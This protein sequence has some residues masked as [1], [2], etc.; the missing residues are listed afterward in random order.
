MSTTG[1]AELSAQPPSDL[2]RALSL[3]AAI[4]AGMYVVARPIASQF[5]PYSPDVAFTAMIALMLAA[6]ISLKRFLSK[7]ETPHAARFPFSVAAVL[8]LF[9]ALHVIGLIRS[10]N[11]G[12]GLPQFCDIAAYVLLLLCGFELNRHDR[13]LAML[14]I[15]G[16]LGIIAV[17]AFAGIW[18]HHIDLPRLW[19]A[20]DAG[21]EA[22]PPE[23]QS[24]TGQWRFRGDDAFATFG[25]PNSLAGFMLPGICLLAGALFSPRAAG[26]PLNFA[27]VCA[28]ALIAMM[29]WALWVTHSKGGCVAA[30]AGLWFLALQHLSISRPKLSRALAWLTAAGIFGMVVLL[31]LGLFGVLGARPFGD[32]IQ[33]RLE[34]WTSALGMIRDHPFAGTGLYGFPENYTFYKLPLG[35]EVK[36][37]H[38]DYINL[39]AEL[40]PLAPLCYLALW[41]FV[42]KT[43]VGKSNVLASETG[44]DSA[45][46]RLHFGLI[47]GG[48]LALLMLYVAFHPF[49]SAEAIAFLSG[50]PGSTFSGLLHTLALPL[51]FGAV[52]LIL[53]P[54]FR[55]GTSWIPGARAAIGAVLIHQIV[56]FDIKAQAVAAAIF[57]LGGMLL[58]QRR[59]SSSDS[60]TPPPHRSYWFA[61][62]LRANHYAARL[63][64]PLLAAALFYPAVV[65]PFASGLPRANAESMQVDARQ[66]AM[67][68]AALHIK[69]GSEAQ[70]VTLREEIADAWKNA[71]DAAPY[72]A[73]A[74]TEYAMA[75]EA[76]RQIRPESDRAAEVKNYLEKAAALRPLAPS[77]KLSLGDYI[78][79]SAIRKAAG[80]ATQKAAAAEALGWY[81]AAAARY[82]FAPGMRLARGDALLLFGDADAADGAYLEALR[83]DVAILDVNVYLSSIFT[84]SRPG[85][86]VKHGYDREILSR[87]RSAKT[88]SRGLLLRRVIS[89]AWLILQGR[90][91]PGAKPDDLKGLENEMSTTIEDLISKTEDITERAHLAL[92]AALS[93][94]LRR[95]DTQPEKKTQDWARARTLQKLSAQQ[96]K[97][98]SPAVM[99]DWLS[100]QY[101]PV[102]AVP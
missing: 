11:L 65:V 101:G 34:Y 47:G 100:K 86:F 73:N 48:V 43:P 98:G 51:I 66:M 96:G 76:L 17:E 89:I 1:P 79:R 18:Q 77:P 16:L 60:Q 87:L 90:N 80:S 40:G 33:V 57:L 88:Q 92:F 44:D 42:L 7:D 82:P 5:E 10:P 94:E 74:W 23:L 46:R 2:S 30:L 31:A 15:P 85:A 12:M 9:L 35:T 39:W 38:N 19:G 49:N 64:L 53:E 54:L 70:Y 71:A 36:D 25:N 37:A 45:V 59:E 102:K 20:V 58:A 14:L 28:A 83:V 63:A 3:A 75:I 91:P 6:V 13:T 52:V 50:E 56:D 27:R 81:S 41:W 84:D 8:A 93:H 78:F 69:A 22:L 95:A 97:P 32:S 62:S 21:R 67:G 29:L 26:K 99:F 4:L 61:L 68:A 55:N 72:D 24:N